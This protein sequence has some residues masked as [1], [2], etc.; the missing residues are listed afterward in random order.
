MKAEVESKIEIQIRGLGDFSAG[1]EYEK[2][3]KS[4]MYH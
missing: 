1:L 2:Q 4:L 3:F